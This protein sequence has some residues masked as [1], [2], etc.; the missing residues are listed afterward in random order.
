MEDSSSQVTLREI[1]KTAVVAAPPEEVWEAWTTPAG[2]R[3]FFAPEAH[4]VMEPG[5]AY[6]LYFDLD[7]PEGLR[8]SE[9][10]VV[11]EREVPHFFSVSWNFPPCIPSLRNTYTLVGVHLQGL[12]D[13]TT[14]V[15]VTHSKW[16]VGPDW[17]EG[18]R[19]FQRAWKLVLARLRRRFT[20]GPIDWSA[21]YVPEDLA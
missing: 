7:Q 15:V 9:G 11:R 19:Y 8:G 3:T 20:H 5:G 14:R 12:P 1:C 10:C 4:I 21:P 18:L 16:G 2:A 6:E 17:E 13:G